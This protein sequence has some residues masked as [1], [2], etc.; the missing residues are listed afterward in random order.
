MSQ[1]YYMFIT[2]SP[3]NFTV[4]SYTKYVT[5]V[6]SFCGMLTDPEFFEDIMEVGIQG[7]GQ[8]IFLGTP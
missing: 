5:T 7:G 4:E 8:T 2:D 6:D 3:D 1:K